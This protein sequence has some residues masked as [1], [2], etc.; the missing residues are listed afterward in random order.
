MSGVRLAALY[1]GFSVREVSE[2]LGQHGSTIHRFVW[3]PI[4]QT[5]SFDRKKGI[6]PMGMPIAVKSPTRATLYSAPQAERCPCLRTAFAIRRK[7]HCGPASACDVV[8][9]DQRIAR[10]VLSSLI[11]RLQSQLAEVRSL[12]DE[13]RALSARQLM[14]GSTNLVLSQLPRQ[15]TLSQAAGRVA[16]A[17]NLLHG[18]RFNTVVRRAGSLT[19]RVDDRDFPFALDDPESVLMV[20]EETLLFAHAILVLTAPEQASKGLRCVSLRRSSPEPSVPF[21]GLTEVR[22]GSSV[23][24]LRYDGVLADQ[25][26]DRPKREDLTFEAVVRTQIKVLRE[27]SDGFDQLPDLVLDAIRNGKTS[28]DDVAATLGMSSATLRRKL[29]ELGTNFRSLSS[30]VMVERADALLSTSITLDDL[31]TQLGFSDVRSFNRAYR[32][33]KGITPAVARRTALQ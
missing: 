1:D 23:Y 31:A 13:A 19:F 28:Q 6:P 18:G 2:K 22:Y 8:G 32:A 14:P 33:R 10:G 25:L 29:S 9:F 30:D 24:G 21:H 17:F 12:G 16:D 11:D 7:R 15:V 5:T 20:M 4:G 3:G 27:M 26:V